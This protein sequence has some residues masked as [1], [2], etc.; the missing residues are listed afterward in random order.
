MS[1]AFRAMTPLTASEFEYHQAQHRALAMFTEH[2]VQC[3][4]LPSFITRACA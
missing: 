3:A 2:F 4:S 1:L